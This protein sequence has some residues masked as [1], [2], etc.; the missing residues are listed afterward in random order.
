M[1]F[2]P[3]MTNPVGFD[4]TASMTSGTM[5]GLPAMG[6]TSS[7]ASSRCCG[8]GMATQMGNVQMLQ[9]EMTLMQLTSMLMG[10]L[11]G[12]MMGLNPSAAGT[13]GATSA[14]DPVTGTGGLSGG[15][16]AGGSGGGSA[17]GSSSVGAATSGQAVTDASS[18]SGAGALAQSIVKDASSHTTNVGGLCL[19]NVGAVLRR[20]GIQCGPAPAAHMVD[21]DLARSPKMREVRV[22]K[23]QLD[24]LPAGAV[25]VWEKG[26]GLPY[27][28]ISISMGNG[29]EWS[30]PLRN[31]MHLNTS[32]RVFLPVEK[33]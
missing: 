26:S 6:G 14:T 8:A 22:S 2:N 7:L 1:A 5:P 9:A 18:L 11:M 23:D 10:M 16:P 31:Q 19:K 28:H 13:G 25:I 12:L 21:D 4:P 30:G 17:G 27:G 32:Y 24:K 15:K 29:K 3:F 20:Q 33:G